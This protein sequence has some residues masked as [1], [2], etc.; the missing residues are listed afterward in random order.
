MNIEHVFGCTLGLGLG[1]RLSKIIFTLNF[2]KLFYSVERF[3]ALCPENDISLIRLQKNAFAL[4][5]KMWQL[6]LMR[7][8]VKCWKY[9]L[10][11]ALHLLL[12]FF[13]GGGWGH[14]FKLSPNAVAPIHPS[15]DCNLVTNAL[16]YSTEYES[17]QHSTFNLTYMH[18]DLQCKMN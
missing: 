15:I 18:T 11:V 13:W 4:V 14:S 5:R 12:L 1:A 8:N 2:L 3:R 10:L 16:F 7:S 6:N 17:I 9:L